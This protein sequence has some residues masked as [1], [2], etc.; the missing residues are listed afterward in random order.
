MNDYGSLVVYSS[1]ADTVIR[2]NISDDTT[3]DNNT[4]TFIYASNVDSGRVDIFDRYGLKWIYGESLPTSNSL[5]DGYGYSIA[6]SDN[7]VYVGAPYS[8]DNLF[9]AGKIYVYAKQFGTT[10]WTITD[11]EIE[12]PAVSK[13]KQA[14]LY[15]K[16]TNQLITY[17]D[18]ID[19]N[20]GKIAGI[21]D[22]EIKFKTF[23]D[24]A[25]YSI[26]STSVN[27]DDGAAWKESQVG[28]LWWDLRTTKFINSYSSDIVYRNSTWST[29]ATGASV[30]VYEWVGTKYIPADWDALADTEAG[31]ASGISGTSL[32]GNSAYSTVKRYDKIS[33]TFKNTYYFWVKNKK[34]VPDVPGRAISASD[35]SSLIGNPRGQ[36]Y[37]YLALTGTNSFSL[38]NVKQS[39]HDADVV[40]SVEY[41][42]TDKTDQNI[43]AQWKLI[44]ENPTSQLPQS[45]EDKWIDS[46]CGKDVNDRLVPDMNLPPKLRYGIENRP[47]QGIF[48]NRFEALK[49]FV[50]R[51][52]ISLLS[53]QIIENRDIT[54]LLS[55][56]P[57]PST[58]TG[59]YDAVLDTDAEL[60]FAGVGSFTRPTF[61]TITVVDGA[62]TGVSI[63]AE[64]RGYLIAPFI[65]VTGAGTGAII[66]AKIST[67]GKV[68]GVEIINGGQGYDATTTTL[69]IRDYSVLVHSDS[70]ALNS[71]SIY[72]YDPVYKTWS[73]ILSQTYDTRKY[74]DYVDW[75]ANGYNQF[76]AIDFAV[77]TFSDLNS[78]SPLVG[79]IVKVRTDNSGNWVLLKKYAN[80]TSIDW[81]QSYV[82]VGAENGTIQL[83]TTLYKFDNSNVGYDSSLF[84]GNIFDNSASKELRIILNALRDKIFID[85]LKE[86]YLKLF[87]TCV[88]YALTEQN[89]IDWIFKTSFVKS[90]HNV[91]ELKQKVTYNSDNLENYEDYVNEVKPYRT[92][93]REYVSSYTKTDTS[94]LSVTDFDLPPVYDNGIVTSI[95]TRIVDGQVDADNS[96]IL[97]YP[98]KHWLDNIGFTITELA[99]VDGGSGYITEP[100][101]RIVSDSGSGATGR[102]FIANGKVNRL[103][104]LTPG[105]GYLSAPTV[106]I[107]GGLSTTGKSA[108]AVAI[109]GNSVVRS[110]LIKMKFDRIT[111]TYFITQLQETETFTS[112]GSRLQFPLA[113]APNVRIGQAT[114]TINGV[115]AL[116]ENYNLSIVK[117]NSKGYAS[118][119]GKLTF[120][121]NPPAGPLVITYI[122][123]W[124]LLNAADRIQ[125]YYNPATGD[126]GKDLSQLMTGIDYGGVV[127]DGLGFDVSQGWGSLPYFSEKWDSADPTFDDFITTVAAGT[128]EFTLPYTPPED[129]RINVYHIKS[130]IDSYTSNGST[131]LY[132]YTFEVSNPSIIVTKITQAKSTSTTFGSYQSVDS[133][134]TTVS[135]TN[136]IGSGTN[137]LFGVKR[138]ND[139][140]EISIV[141]PGAGYAVND[142][143]KILGTTVNGVSPDNDIRITVIGV[144]PLGAITEISVAGI[145]TTTLVVASTTG[146]VPGMTILGTGFTSLQKVVLV[147]NNTRL[148]ISSAPNTTPVGTLTFTKNIAGSNILSLN[149]TVGIALNDTLSIPTIPTFSYGYTVDAILNSTEVR[150][151]QIIYTN[152]PGGTP[153][154][155]SHTLVEPTDVTIFNNGTF[156]LTS[157]IIAGNLIQVIGLL[158]PARIDD[159]HYVTSAVTLP[160]TTADGGL[161]LGT[162]TA[163]YDGGNSLSTF[164]PAVD[165][166]L[167]AGNSTNLPAVTGSVMVTP[168]NK[169]VGSIAI[170]NAGVYTV[171]PTVTIGQSPLISSST[172]YNAT[173]GTVSMQVISATTV[174]GFVGGG[175]NIND[176]L[177][178]GSSTFRVVTLAGTGV[179]RVEVING[180]VVTGTLVTGPRLTTVS[181]P[182]IIVNY[183][184][185]KVGT[186]VPPTPVTGPYYVTLSIPIQPNA[187][188]PGSFYTIAGNTNPNYNGAWLC[189]SSTLITITLQ[190]LTDPGEWS[191]LET[192]VV[193]KPLGNACTLVL[194]YGVKAVEL[195]T[196]GSGYIQPPAVTFSAGTASASAVLTDTIYVPSSYFVNDGDQFIFR[197]STSDG[198]FKPQDQD[199]DT[200]LSGGD[201]AYSTAT[202][203]AAEDILVDGDGFVTPTTSSAP[204]EVVPGQVVDAVAIKVYDKPSTGS[205]NIKVD[206]Y[207]ADG[208]ETDF[209]FTQTINSQQAVI[210]KVSDATRVDGELVPSST[211]KSINIDYTV[212]Y[213]NNLIKFATAPTNKQVV[214]IFNFG[215]SG[216]GIL[217]LD[218]FIADGTTTEFIT[219]AP[220]ITPVT[221]LVYIDGVAVNP[222]LFETDI[223]YDSAKR[224]GIRFGNAP[225]EGSLINFV[226][227]SGSTQTFAITKTERIPANGSLTY[228][229]S[230]D[231]GEAL[232]VESN[233]IVR[234]DQRILK[235]ASN[236]YFTI[237]S[238]RLNY[239]LDPAKFLPYTLDINDI[240][241]YA[242]GKL[243]SIGTD[244]IIDLSGINV[245]ITREVYSN[246]SGKQLIVTVNKGAEYIYIPRTSTSLPRITFN[247]VYT[248]ANYVEVI[249]SY[250]HDV[251]DIQRTT[252]KVTSSLELTPDTLGYYNYTRLTS[253]ILTL[254][255]EIID[256]Q[257]VWVIKNGRLLSPSI[258]YVLLD[259]K[260]SIKLGQIPSLD[261]EYNLI[262]FSNNV[263]TTG[264]AYMQFKD[265]LNRT[266]FKRLSLNK[267]TRLAKDLKY[268]DL[269]I[270]VEDASTFDEPNP[271]INKPG[272]VEIRGE[273]IEYFSKTGNV[274]GQLRRGTLGTGTPL[275]HFVGSFVQDIGAGETIPYAE[276]SIVQQIVSDGTNT[277]NI[278]FIPT[279]GSASDDTGVANWFSNFNYV[280]KGTYNETTLYSLK[281]I[282]AY[283]GYYYENISASKGIAPTDATYW[284]LYSTI[285]VGYGQAD[286]IEVFVG[287]YDDIT[288]WA[289]TVEYSVGK[290]VTIG[291]YTY[292]CIVA[293]TSSTNFSDNKDNWQ[294]FVGNIRLKK[295][296]Y[297][298]YNVNNA[299][300]SPAG[301]VYF[302]A[303]F[304]V[305][306][307]TSQLRLTNTLKFG[308]RVTVVKRTGSSWDGTLNIQYDDNKISRFLKATPGIWYTNIVKSDAVL[309]TSFD[310]GANTFDT[311]SQTFDQG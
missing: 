69:T 3:F 91:G 306:G 62:I 127:V 115:E 158:P 196:N 175:Y 301:D 128:H 260:A 252:V 159:D 74:W 27:V 263:L 106:Y 276:E 42:I 135:G 44:S 38:V 191:D 30:D 227:V 157:P 95:N 79:Q 19:P 172:D 72:S 67:L 309:S 100:V 267:Q 228:N 154:S 132:N 124:S 70:Q 280:L 105:K 251:L 107:E 153:I 4:T 71:W 98:W 40:L 99:L 296:P 14:F 77:T 143:I 291:S 78:I 117:S 202:G 171:K 292:R 236:N 134:E 96:K 8:N 194:T 165:A 308:T 123:D 87:F 234:V 31:L 303:D 110:N 258:D 249:S 1:N 200:A 17:L 190:F 174:G 217:D 97:S 247:D 177:T 289:P 268:N 28:T 102:A 282:V 284:T 238:N 46:L 144:G 148:I 41:W 21:A 262:T 32:Y 73:R 293:H 48:V 286:D 162:I 245:K 201:L 58:I 297:E 36:G 111:Q 88:R 139:L 161:S 218:Y 285:P 270:T 192:T 178:I 22:E 219:K 5:S 275:I 84:D 173:L 43:H 141:T 160:G 298:V 104:L 51:A 215:F 243:L 168:I 65:T 265:M 138:N 112:T 9:K 310:S 75:Y 184:I 7:N 23:Y 224:V 232:P 82:I 186:G 35:V 24:P 53:Y 206:N 223:T 259:D 305:N 52:N 226:I 54:D 193:K 94:E 244:Y 307:T 45:I 121:V 109:I 170:N 167:N 235:T 279:K 181:S 63:A 90:N 255:R 246:Y 156:L 68:T 16:S 11:Q 229:L 137:A 256:D 199:Y 50:E 214:S 81:T 220:W 198:S 122:K 188:R 272:A 39:L 86:Q 92:K 103:V 66:K 210:V 164:N 61:G 216:S 83:S 151:N 283:N 233:M 133:V 20:Q 131:L 179:G 222:D 269:T 209:E 60:R 13:I 6:V 140:Y 302:D 290:I 142:I 248:G 10:S 294:F 64:G 295:S 187:P 254:D 47:R 237:K 230:Y 250:N 225:A 2:W 182:D 304:A 239:S 80:S 163:T 212:D 278:N 299:P 281:D 149:T 150:L 114:V 33:K 130:N 93:I 208:T 25:V 180:E 211:V 169:S 261:D 101:V 37:Q 203:I 59:L 136:I 89:Y 213:K 113:W 116:R 197:K 34:T 274:L 155:F 57:E 288:P 240:I 120:T 145:A 26:G 277:I 119:S 166:D 129:T 204:E 266:H 55:A 273:R 85:D 300:D 56:D 241:V 146:I 195:I 221:S 185:S 29:L 311:S 264:I 118:Y 126:L 76:T 287:G 207:I 125:Y 253:G 189:S 231:I 205:A 108:R 12:K 271:A 15:N 183:F 147:V 176:I 18:V 242:D 49:Q 257:Y 152:I